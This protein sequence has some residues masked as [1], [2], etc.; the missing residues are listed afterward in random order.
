MC[1]TFV[2]DVPRLS[3]GMVCGAVTESKISV[4][5]YDIFILVGIGGYLDGTW[6][7]RGFF[8]RVLMMDVLTVMFWGTF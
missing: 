4:S 5:I 3:K 1:E 7:A 6:A 8:A 2:G